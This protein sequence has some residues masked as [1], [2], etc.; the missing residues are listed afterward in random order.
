MNNIS[1]NAIESLLIS[2]VTDIGT[3]GGRVVSSLNELIGCVMELASAELAAQSAMYC[4]P[5]DDEEESPQ[6][7]DALSLR[8]DAKYDVGKAV[9]R[10]LNKLAQQ[11]R[12]LNH[13]RVSLEQIKESL[14][15]RNNTLSVSMQ[16]GPKPGCSCVAT[17]SDK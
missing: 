9:D 14:H 7:N 6:V 11:E 12:V 5:D 13:A 3:A 8:E 10:A 17:T 2:S 4:V 1:L 16:I 15:L